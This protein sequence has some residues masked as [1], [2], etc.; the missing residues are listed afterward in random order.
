MSSLPVVERLDVFEAKLLLNGTYDE[1]FSTP[2]SVEHLKRL[3]PEPHRFEF[4]E[5][6]PTAGQVL[7]DVARAAVE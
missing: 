3:W 1:I 5:S 2:A 4:V 6:G 7:D